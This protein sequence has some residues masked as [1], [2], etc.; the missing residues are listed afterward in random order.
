MLGIDGLHRDGCPDHSAESE[1]VGGLGFWI[2]E[3]VVFDFNAG[4]YL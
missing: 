4:S 3:E 1:I 2:Q